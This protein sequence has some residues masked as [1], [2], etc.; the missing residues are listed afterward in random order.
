MPVK[1][2]S[3]PEDVIIGML[4]SVPESSLVEIFWKAVVREDTAPLNSAEKRA[5]KDALDAYTHGTT[6]NWKSV[7]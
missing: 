7:R 1:K 2:I 5:V 6:T 4:R 3:I